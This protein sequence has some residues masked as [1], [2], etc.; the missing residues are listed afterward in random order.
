MFMVPQLIVWLLPESLPMV[1]ELLVSQ[2]PVQPWLL[3]LKVPDHQ[4]LQLQLQQPLL[5]L[6]HSNT[7]TQELLLR[8][9]VQHM[10]QQP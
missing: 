5:M 1:H 3:I 2:P 9:P 8:Q 7:A 10:Q 6:Q 4:M